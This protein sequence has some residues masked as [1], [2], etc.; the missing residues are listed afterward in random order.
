[1][2]RPASSIPAFGLILL[3]I[4][5]MTVHATPINNTFGLASPNTLLGF[6]E[7]GA[8]GVSVQDQYISQGVRFSKP[9]VTLFSNNFEGMDQFALNQGFTFEIEFLGTVTEAAFSIMTNPG[10]SNFRALLGG[11]IV[12][13]IT[14][15]TFY[16]SND[17]GQSTY[18][19]FQGITFDSIE[20]ITGAGGP[21]L[22]FRLDNLQFGEV[23][24]SVPEPGTIAL[25]ALGVVGIGFGK[26]GK[27]GQ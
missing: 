15:S 10:T 19:G 21:V 20:I 2:N 7:F 16:S 12:E 27:R 4:L 18:F 23:T 9:L 26:R 24:A 17:S 1:M 25:L 8:D 6:D 11:S 14:S 3:T 5:S 22:P 13:Q